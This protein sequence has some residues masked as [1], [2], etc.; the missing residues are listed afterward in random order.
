MTTTTTAT[1]WLKG[2]MLALSHAC[3]RRAGR[4]AWRAGRGRVGARRGAQV[5]Q[6]MRRV[7]ACVCACVAVVEKLR[8]RSRV[9][10]GGQ[11]RV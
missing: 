7:R 11:R 3:V 2:R 5:A 6:R 4:V 9:W 1:S 8:V 10:P